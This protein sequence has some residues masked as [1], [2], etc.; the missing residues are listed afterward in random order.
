MT[1]FFSDIE[2]FTQIAST[3]D[4]KI[5][6]KFLNRL[7]SLFDYIAD[8]L[9]GQL[10]K[11]ETVGDAYILASGLPEIDKNHAVNVA[12]F[13]LLLKELAGLVNVPIQDTPVR[14]RIGLHTGNVAAGIVGTKMPRYCLYGDTINYA[15]R[16]ESTGVVGKIQISEETFECLSVTNE[17]IIEERG[18]VE[19]KGK[20]SVK[21]YFLIDYSPHNKI[22]NK[23]F[24]EEF[25]IEAMAMLDNL[26]DIS[27]DINK[28]VT[29]RGSILPNSISYSDLK[30][31][32]N[33]NVK[34]VK[35][36]QVVPILEQKEEPF[37]FV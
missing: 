22:L 7:F 31:L 17:F 37:Y 8:K 21:T 24:M 15:S 36:T 26:N 28:L 23:K 25:R 34:E 32:L 19:V 33:G 10:Y 14:V 6:M 20:G 4:P 30:N 3:L 2:G 9:P 35:R 29:M 11:I 16:M 1:I 12:N 5:V 18:E 27:F 13:S